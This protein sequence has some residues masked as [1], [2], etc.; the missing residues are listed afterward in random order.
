MAGRFG[1]TAGLASESAAAGTPRAGRLTATESTHLANHPLGGPG[2]NP[3]TDNSGAP[4]GGSDH[5]NGLPVVADSNHSF[6]PF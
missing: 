6:P 1:W 4:D 2:T 3:A 5:Y